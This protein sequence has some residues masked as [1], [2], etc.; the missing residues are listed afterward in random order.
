MAKV[1]EDIF[2]VH[3][4]EPVEIRKTIL[5]SS[6]Q[7]VKLLQRYENIREVRIRKVEQINKLRKNFRE[8][9]VI[10][11]KLKQEMP[12][13]NIRIPKVG[14]KPKSNELYKLEDE[15]KQIEG[16]LSKFS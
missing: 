7:T 8:L 11:N 14:E 4:K 16:K 2:Y 5:E 13:V 12:K 9:V 15:L 10:V 6:K 1:E 3:I